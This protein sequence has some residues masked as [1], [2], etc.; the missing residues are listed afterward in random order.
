MPGSGTC[1]CHPQTFLPRLGCW[2]GWSYSFRPTAESYGVSAQRSQTSF[3]VVWSSFRGAFQ[4]V[5]GM[6]YPSCMPGLKCNQP[7]TWVLNC[8]KPRD[9]F[10]RATL[11]L[12]HVFPHVY[13]VQTRLDKEGPRFFDS[14]ILRFFD[15]FCWVPCQAYPHKFPR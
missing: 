13:K 3:G 9:P 14:L 4:G 8:P 7:G 2:W 5:P 15:R 6:V 10:S 12:L 11:K 1:R